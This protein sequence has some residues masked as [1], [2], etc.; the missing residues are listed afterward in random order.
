MPHI[1]AG[2]GQFFIQE[3]VDGSNFDT[4]RMEWFPFPVFRTPRS[5]VRIAGVKQAVI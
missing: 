1:K 4:D 3:A 5:F 2:G